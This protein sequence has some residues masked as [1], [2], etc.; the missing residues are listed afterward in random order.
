MNY[1]PVPNF[2][3]GVFTPEGSLSSYF[4]RQFLPGKLHRVIYDPEGLLSTIPAIC[5]AMLGIFTGTFL[6]STS[7]NFSPQKKAIVLFFVGILN[8]YVGLAWSLIFPINKTMWTSTFVLFSGGWSLILLAV[9]YYVIDVKNIKKWSLPFIWIGTNSILI[10][11]CAHGLIN[12]ES[13]AQFLF[14]GI[15]NAIPT[16]WQQACLWIGVLI[17]QLFLLRFLY[18][19]KWFLKI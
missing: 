2:G 10:Y 6:K 17:I 3:A 9:F 1:F 12:F 7:P 16:I 8:I 19:K 5:T 18:E 13:T 11:V 14:G 15:I 4:D